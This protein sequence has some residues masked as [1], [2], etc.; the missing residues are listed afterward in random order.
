MNYFKSLEIVLEKMAYCLMNGKIIDI[1][2]FQIITWYASYISG[3]IRLVSASGSMVFW[4]EM[5]KEVITKSTKNRAH[6]I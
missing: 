5:I 6:S 3:I 4:I 1:I 2:P